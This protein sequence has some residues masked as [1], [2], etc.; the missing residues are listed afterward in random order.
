MVPQTQMLLILPA[1]SRTCANCRIFFCLLFSPIW[2]LGQGQ[3]PCYPLNCSSSGTTRNGNFISNLT[4]FHYP[5]RVPVQVWVLLSL[6]F[7]EA[8]LC[9]FPLPT[10]CLLGHSWVHSFHRFHS[11]LTHTLGREEKCALRHKLLSF[12][13]VW[14]CCTHLLQLLPAPSFSKPA[15]WLQTV[16]LYPSHV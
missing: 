13:P 11:S 1:I 4:A 7:P 8:T 16:S 15:G 5:H 6:S 10:P 9:F 2:G 3:A 12:I 14:L